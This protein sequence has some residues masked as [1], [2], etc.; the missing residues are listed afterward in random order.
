M[1]HIVNVRSTRL[2]IQL[3]ETEIQQLTHYWHQQKGMFRRFAL[4][5]H[6]RLSDLASYRDDMCILDLAASGP[7]YRQVGRR[8]LP[9]LGADPTGKPVTTLRPEAYRRVVEAILMDALTNERPVAHEIT[10]DVDGQRMVMQQLVLPLSLNGVEIDF[11]LT[12]SKVLA[13]DDALFEAAV[14]EKERVR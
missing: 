8:M 6:M 9:R 12:Y 10:I 2:E 4:L 11:L 7:V 13:W 5:E 14:S 1:P 3:A